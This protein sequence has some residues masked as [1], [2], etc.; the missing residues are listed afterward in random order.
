MPISLRTAAACVALALAPFGAVAKP[1]RPAARAAA[2]AAPDWLTPL[3]AAPRFSIFVKAL[4]DN[5]L[6]PQIRSANDL[7]VFA[8]TD[9]AFNALPPAQL[10]WLISPA[11]ASQLR[12][13]L[14]QLIIGKNLESSTLKG[15]V[16]Q[17]VS[18]GGAPVTLD[19]SGESITL[20]GAQVIDAE[21]HAGRSVTVYA[22]GK[23]PLPA[24]IALPASVR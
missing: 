5:G 13:L 12:K 17:V 3:R 7:T 15:S 14:T 16:G 6:T 22:L 2:P 18:I 23:V 1:A 11:G 4:D 21:L 24:D 20:N 19:G 8:P 10:A 9:E